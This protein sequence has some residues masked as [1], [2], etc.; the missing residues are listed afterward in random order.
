MQFLTNAMF[1]PYLITRDNYDDKKINENDNNS[2]TIIEKVGES[3]ILPI[4]LLLIGSLS[5][6]WGFFGRMDDYIK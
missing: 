1:L 6:G 3:K 2:L 5:I 4:L